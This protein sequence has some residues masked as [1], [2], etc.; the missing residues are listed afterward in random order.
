[1]VKDDALSEEIE[2]EQRILL[3][4]KKEEEIKKEVNKLKRLYKNVP[5]N[6]IDKVYSLIENSAFMTITLKYLRES[7]NTNG[8]TIVYK[9]G[10]NQFGTKDNPDLKSYNATL[11][12]LS[13]IT[14]QLTD[15][16]LEPPPKEPKQED[17]L[18]NIINRGKN[19]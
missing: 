11:K 4:K 13:S 14:K 17:A 16:G 12:N 7:I 15:L 1:M 18:Y 2:R 5:K 9:N 8:T 3:K 19:G 10:E 6:T